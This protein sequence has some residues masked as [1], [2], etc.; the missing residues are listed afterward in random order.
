[1]E[2]STDLR[3]SCKMLLSPSLHCRRR[4]EF[5][6]QSNFMLNL[7]KCTFKLGSPDPQYV[8][9]PSKKF[10]FLSVVGYCIGFHLNYCGVV[11]TL[12]SSLKFEIQ[13]I[14]LSSGTD[15]NGM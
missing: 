13:L 2:L 6:D 14:N 5:P 4:H 11:C 7:M 9:M 15:L 8:V 10:T 12:P 1:M 3:L